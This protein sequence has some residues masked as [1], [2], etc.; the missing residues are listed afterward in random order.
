MALIAALMNATAQ[1]AMSVLSVDPLVLRVDEF[2]SSDDIALMLKTMPPE[3]AWTSCAWSEEQGGKGCAN[4]TSPPAS[5]TLMRK[6][7]DTFGHNL[8]SWTHLPVMRLL[9]EAEPTPLHTDCEGYVDGK[10]VLNT[11]SSML[12]LSAALDGGA[13]SFPRA[14]AGLGLEV[15]PS[16]GTLLVWR[17]TQRDGQPNLAA[18][19]SV[20][21]VPA[22]ASTRFALQIPIGVGGASSRHF[23]M[24]E[25]LLS[26]NV[27]DLPSLPPSPLPPPPPTSP[28]PQSPCQPCPEKRTLLFGSLPKG[29]AR[30]PGQGEVLPCCRMMPV[31]STRRLSASAMP[32]AGPV[33][34]ALTQDHR[35]LTPKGEEYKFTFKK[36]LLTP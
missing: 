26:G 34:N 29:G 10:A 32:D 30:K 36:A 18:A 15:K 31:I 16:A 7:S 2:L 24:V 20:T 27:L 11:W 6:L 28:P 33:F 23:G 14:R 25:V 13:L 4:L 35:V 3:S 9:P 5:S 19:H 22:S 17:N 21:G 12:Y 1:H 8:S